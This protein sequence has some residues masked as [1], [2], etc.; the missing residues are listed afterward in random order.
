[1]WYVVQ[2]YSGREIITKQLCDSMIHDNLL[3]QCFIPRGEKKFKQKGKW[4]TVPITMFPGYLFMETEYGKDVYHELKRIP[5]FTKILGTGYELV[6]IQEEEERF[7]Q[8]LMDSSHL[9]QMST[10][11]LLGQ[12]VVVYE[13]PLQGKEGLIR[14]IDRKKRMAVIETDF[15]GRKMDI[16]VG[17]EIVMRVEEENEIAG[18]KVRTDWGIEGV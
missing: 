4:I 13:G 17:L 1:M 5:E 7:L 6:P 15:L 11:V 3:K 9:V 18:K 16:T 10:G 8:G 12:Q 2:V 14:K